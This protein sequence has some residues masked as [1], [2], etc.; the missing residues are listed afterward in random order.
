[1]GCYQELVAIQQFSVLVMFIM[2]DCEERMEIS[3][4]KRQKLLRRKDD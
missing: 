4:V 1:M 2:W 3:L